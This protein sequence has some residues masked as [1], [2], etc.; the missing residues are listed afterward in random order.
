M[1]TTPKPTWKF[2]N[3]NGNIFYG[4]SIKR[5]TRRRVVSFKKSGSGFYWLKIS[6]TLPLEAYSK[7]VQQQQPYFKALL[8]W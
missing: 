7:K 6:R 1:F 4:S 5:R 8:L 2:I 3:K